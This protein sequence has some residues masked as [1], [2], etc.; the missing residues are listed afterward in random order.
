MHATPMPLSRRSFLL[1]F[2]SLCVAF[3]PVL[4]FCGW[5]VLLEPVSALVL[6]IF[7]MRFGRMVIWMIIN[8]LFYIGAFTLL[9]MFAHYV[10]RFLSSKS[11]RW[12]L[13]IVFLL[14]P[15][16][17]SFARV[18]TYS[19]FDGSGGRYTFWEAVDRY[20]EKRLR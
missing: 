3:V 18:L 5:F 4:I 20:F 15:I 14:L 10:T 11:A 1:C 17:C 12:F 8:A 19:G 13:L 9:G 6:E 7:R 16:F 2:V